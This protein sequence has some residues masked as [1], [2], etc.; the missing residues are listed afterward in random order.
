MGRGVERVA[1]R[2]ESWDSFIVQKM[3]RGISSGV[4]GPLS[5]GH[6]GSTEGEG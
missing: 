2:S 4:R 6:R 5:S 3:E 1:G